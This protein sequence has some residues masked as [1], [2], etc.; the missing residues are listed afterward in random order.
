MLFV[1]TSKDGLLLNPKKLSNK[2]HNLKVENFPSS[3][4]NSSI[5]KINK[6]RNPNDVILIFGSH[7]IANEVF[8]EFEIPFDTVLI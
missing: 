3:D 6:V 1:S 5:S 2:L 4:I 8:S 7:Y